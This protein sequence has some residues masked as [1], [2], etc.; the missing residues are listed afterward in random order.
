MDDL[1]AVMDAIGADQAVL[2][3]AQE[4]LAWRRSSRPL[5]RRAAG[6][7]LFDPTAKGRKTDDYPWAL[8]DEDWRVRLAEPRDGW[9]RT[10]F[11]KALLEEWSPQAGRPGVRS[12]VRQPHAARAQPRISPGL[13]PDDEDSDVSDVLPAVNVPTVVLSSETERG[14]GSYVAERIPGAR[15][16]ELPAS[17]RSIYHWVDDDAHEIAVRGAEELVGAVG[18]PPARDQ[19]LATV[20]FTDIVGSTSVRAEMG[21]QAWR[22]ARAHH[23]VVRHQL[24]GFE[25]TK[26]D[27]AGDEFF[28]AFDGPGRA[29]QCARAVVEAVRELGLEVNGTPH[30]R[31]RAHGGQAERNRGARRRPSRRPC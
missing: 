22:V 13:L 7:V 1:R 8:G 16:V 17:L 23:A 15:L 24:G 9:G 27:T 19:V 18:Q 28:A 11:L 6:L 30:G 12:V 3:T 29:I 25:E 26:L 2:W 21:D 31:V 20:L 10:D 5:A 4:A 14:P